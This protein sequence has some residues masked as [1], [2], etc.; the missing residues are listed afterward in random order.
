MIGKRGAIKAADV[1]TAMD[2]LKTTLQ[3][4]RDAQVRKAAAEALGNIGAEPEAVVPL[5]IDALKDKNRELKMGAMTALSQYGSDAKE[6]IPSLREI[7]DEKTDKA[8]SKMAMVAI[9]S[10]N[11]KK[12]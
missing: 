8:L 7:S 6:A 11:G 1:A 4:D 2:L 10:I 12:K 5:L 3:K 9:K